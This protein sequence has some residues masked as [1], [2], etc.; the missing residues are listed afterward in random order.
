MRA[1]VRQL[2]AARARLLPGTSGTSTPCGCRRPAPTTGSASGSAGTAARP[3]GRPGSAPRGRGRPRRASA[4]RPSRARAAARPRRPSPSRR[5]GESRASQSASASHMFPIPATSDWSSSVSP[6]QR[7]PSAARRRASI[8]SMPR[9]PLEDVRAEPA[10]RARVQLE[11]GAVP[12]DGLGRL[13]AQHEPRR[14]AAPLAARPQRPAP[15]QAQVRPH[16]DAALEAKHAG[17]CRARSPIRARLPS[18]RS[19][20]R[21]TCARGCG[22]SA[23]TRWPTSACRRSAPPGGGVSPSGTLPR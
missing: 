20:T 14:A 17:S 8:A 16:D 1:H 7:V 9:R 2:R 19:A 12:E 15:G 3:G 6:N 22:D 13:A 10:E 5:H 21:S 18:I 11:H 4:R 23:S